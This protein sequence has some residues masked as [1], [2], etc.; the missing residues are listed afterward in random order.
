MAGNFG[1][2]KRKSERTLR[3]I[4]ATN[5]TLQLLKNA[6]RRVKT[7]LS[8]RKKKGRK[9]GKEGKI[10]RR[11]FRNLLWTPKRVTLS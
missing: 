7:I 11:C 5:G 9:V 3:P 8:N 4:T 1:K 6:S 2:W 10:I